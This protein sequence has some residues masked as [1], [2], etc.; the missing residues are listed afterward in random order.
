MDGT[1]APGG[2]EK[3]TLDYNELYASLQRIRRYYESY[4]HPLASNESLLKEITKEEQDYL[5]KILAAEEISQVEYDD[6]H[7]IRF[8]SGPLLG[9]DDRVK[10]FDHRRQNVQLKIPL[11]HTEALFWTAVDLRE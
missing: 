11:F 4:F 3:K 1:D 10:K 2:I 9:M 8:I 5:M 7:M 6:H